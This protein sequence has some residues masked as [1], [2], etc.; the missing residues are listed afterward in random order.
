MREEFAKN[1]LK[2]AIVAQT[3][4]LLNKNILQRKKQGLR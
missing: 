4:I 1:S 3:K 2:S